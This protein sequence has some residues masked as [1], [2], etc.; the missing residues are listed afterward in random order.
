M[1]NEKM[2]PG[3]KIRVPATTANLGAGFNCLGI[4]LELYNTL[5][6]QEA[7]SG[8]K[9]EITGEGKDVL[10]K[11]EKNLSLNVISLY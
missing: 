10:P 11:N 1:K 2:N 3:A 8:L 9:I 5:K 6:A 7:R 4:D